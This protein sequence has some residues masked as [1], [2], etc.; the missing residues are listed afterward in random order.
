M[1]KIK[2]NAMTDKEFMSKAKRL[3]KMVQEIQDLTVE[4]EI[5]YE[6]RFGANPSDVDDDYWIDCF[7]YPGASFPTLEQITENAQ[8]HK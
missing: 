8:L 7:H 2:T 6:Q 4:L 1:G 5:E 3:W